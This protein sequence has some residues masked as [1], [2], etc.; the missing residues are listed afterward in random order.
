MKTKITILAILFLSLSISKQAKSQEKF[1]GFSVSPQLG[2][3]FGS[4]GFIPIVPSGDVN[5]FMS[6]YIF[7]TSYIRVDELNLSSNSY[8][9]N[10]VNFLFGKYIGNNYFRF[11]YQAGLGILWGTK[12]GKYLYT[13]KSKPGSLFPFS[14]N[15]YETEKYTTF[16]IPI[17]FGFKFIPIRFMSLG[18]DFKL[19]INGE[20]ASFIPLLSVEFGYL[21]NK[22]SK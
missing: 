11:Q 4:T 20:H 17:N 7:S 19:N 3:D 22:I 5:F 15:Y 16:N 14:R 9:H 12:R 6:D 8:E 1:T 21:R 13:K 18:V 2:Y 10:F